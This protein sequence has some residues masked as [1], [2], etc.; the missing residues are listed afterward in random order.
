MASNEVDRQGQAGSA[1]VE[2]AFASVFLILL[3]LAVFEFGVAFSSYIAVINASRAGATYAS[4]H[5][6]PSDPEYARYADMVQHEARA[7]GLNMEELVVLPPETPEGIAPGEPVKV[8]VVYRLRTF[9]SMMSL[10]IF[11]RM[12]LPPYYT[13]RWT[14]TVPIR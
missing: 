12:G 1:L 4:M 5:P 14:T 3:V 8:T 2:A 13:I 9:S 11:G 10:P 6:N 7:G